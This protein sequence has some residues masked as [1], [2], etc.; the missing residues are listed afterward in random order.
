MF[1]FVKIVPS[2]NAQT[3]VKNNDRRR[4]THG[5]RVSRVCWVRYSGASRVRQGCKI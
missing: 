2:I 1:A 4:E 5:L 3:D